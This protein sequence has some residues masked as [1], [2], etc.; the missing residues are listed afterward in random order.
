MSYYNWKV[1]EYFMSNINLKEYLNR[2]KDLES[3][4]YTQKRLSGSYIQYMDRTA[5]VMPKEKPLTPPEEPKAPE[6]DSLSGAGFLFVLAMVILGIVLICS[7][8]MIVTNEIGYTYIDYVELLKG[9][10]SILIGIVIFIIIIKIKMK[11]NKAF[12]NREKE[13]EKN[14][15]DYNVHLE[16]YN[17]S[18]ENEK[19]NYKR[20]VKEYKDN[21]NSHKEKRDKT[22][23]EF[24]DTLSL[25]EQA[26]EKHYAQG[27]L[28]PKYRN[29]VA[30]SAIAEYLSSGR[31]DKLEGADGAYNL[32]EMELRQNIVIGQLSTIISNI[33]QIKNN[34]YTL[35]Q[36]LTKSNELINGILTELEEMHTDTRLISYF[37]GITALASISPKISVGY[38]D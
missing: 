21:C 15:N 22:T 2:A 30:V 28:F 31:C 34:Q 9:C 3:A 14:I 33:E 29:F 12:S 13:Y 38:I 5:P 25:L 24:D 36:E 7:G 23:L 32:Y 18:V 6:E 16:I 26:L 11:S 10:F 4:I 37:S 1:S 17:Q 35:Y 8:I 27:V 19:E 20:A